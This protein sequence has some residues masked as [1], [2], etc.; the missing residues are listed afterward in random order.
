MDAAP[1]RRFPPVPGLLGWVGLAFIVAA[2][3]SQLAATIFLM[4]LAINRD[5]RMVLPMVCCYLLG[6]ALFG[7]TVVS[8]RL[9][10]KRAGTQP[11]RSSLPKGQQTPFIVALV[12]MLLAT[13]AGLGGFLYLALRL[14][15]MNR[16]L[17][18]IVPLLL[19]GVVCLG[20]EVRMQELLGRRRSRLMGLPPGR[21]LVILV[22]LNLL[23]S[24]A[25]VAIW[26][27][28]R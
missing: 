9:G 19:G 24:A 15:G 10:H 22:L 4:L 23:V 3:G 13:L 14:E 27:R 25:L 26:L 8:W 7:C 18:A 17:V 12:L 21:G 20:A 28:A 11:P 5:S 6:F 2:V 16:F 1:Q